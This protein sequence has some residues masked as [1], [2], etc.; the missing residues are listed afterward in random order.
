MPE[1]ATM[2]NSGFIIMGEHVFEVY[3]R[4]PVILEPKDFEQWERATPNSNH[5]PDSTQL[6]EAIV[7]SFE[8]FSSVLDQADILPTGYEGYL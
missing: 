7:S 8:Q 1:G 2:N 5:I 6:S 4:M 3:N